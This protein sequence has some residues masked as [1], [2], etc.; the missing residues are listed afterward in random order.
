METR[1]AVLRRVAWAA[2]GGAAAL[3]AACDGSAQ[4]AAPGTRA[5]ATAP[6]PT[7]TSTRP[8]EPTREPP[9]PRPPGAIGAGIG[10]A[11]PAGTPRVA[12]GFARA[13]LRII[14][15][16]SARS[17]LVLTVD[18]A[19]IGTV[20]YP[21]ATAYV[22]ILFGGR[23]IAGASATGAAFAITLEARDEVAYTVVVAADG[24]TTRAIVLADD[25]PVATAD[26]C[27]VRFLPLEA[28]AGPLDLVLAG[29]PTIATGVAPFA[30]GP[31]MAVPA[32]I[33]TLEVRAPGQA[34]P[35]LIKPPIGLDAG[36]RYTA[37]LSGSAAAGTLRLTLYPDAA[38][39]ASQ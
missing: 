20:R 9:R 1:R 18:D 2:V 11:T 33:A 13:R 6:A 29:G 5:T 31:S 39:S 37:V 21:E 24:A 8:T 16:A 38:A 17:A 10:A 7:A 12:K 25:Q 22:D 36:D 26:S 23:R 4:I 19:E 27:R 28:A 30:T 14:H 34:T 32:G 15:A 3:L 35:L